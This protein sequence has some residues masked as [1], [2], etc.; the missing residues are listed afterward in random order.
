MVQKARGFITHTWNPAIG[1]LHNCVYCM[2]R[3]MSKRFALGAAYAD[4]HSKLGYAES[5]SV[6]LVCDKADLFGSW[7]SDDGII[8]ILKAIRETEQG[9][10][11]LLLTKNPMRFHNYLNMFS[12]N[13]LLGST[14]E[15]NRDKDYEKYS[16]APKP[17]ERYNAMKSLNFPRKFISIEPI[18]DFD[19]DIF[20][21]WMLDIAPEHV[22]VGYEPRSVEAPKYEDEMEEMKKVYCWNCNK[23]VKVVE[24]YIVPEIGDIAPEQPIV[25]H[26]SRCD[27][28]LKPEIITCYLCK[29]YIKTFY[30]G[31]IMHGG[32]MYHALCLKCRK[33]AEEVKRNRFNL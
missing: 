2:A 18:M 25:A 20:S 26:C 15:T 24:A 19:N 12:E 23:N 6:I 29:D 22:D 10:T 11:F 33:V 30:S 7:Y 9:I 3:E 21:R 13:C 17:S 4:E 32:L 31:L 1:C 14:I 16:S 27:A 8:D 28:I 5:N